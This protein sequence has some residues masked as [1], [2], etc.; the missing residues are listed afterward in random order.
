M[1]T[2]FAV[3][4][5]YSDN[6]LSEMC[7][8]ASN[9]S[10]NRMSVSVEFVVALDQARG[11]S[12]PAAAHDSITSHKT[13]ISSAICAWACRPRAWVLVPIWG[14]RSARSRK[15]RDETSRG[16]RGHHLPYSGL[17]M[18][19]NREELEEKRP[20]PAS[21]TDALLSRPELKCFL[22]CQ[23]SIALC[24]FPISRSSC[25]SS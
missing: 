16:G 14:L 18:K 25:T 2:R 24:S 6:T 12:G 22:S 5:K 9:K 10:P 11:P 20:S 3:G 4:L 8:Y 1:K 21:C 13:H 15:T 17:L 23:T 19:D 7:A